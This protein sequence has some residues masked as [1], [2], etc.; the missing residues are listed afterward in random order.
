MIILIESNR[1]YYLV[2]S[3]NENILFKIEN[4]NLNLKITILKKIP[5]PYQVK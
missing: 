1:K 2:D 5:I 4:N 3:Y